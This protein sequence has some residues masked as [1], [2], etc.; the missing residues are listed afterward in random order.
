[1]NGRL[2]HSKRYGRRGTA[3]VEMAIVTPIL[4]LILLGIIEFGYILYARNILINAAHQGARIGIVRDDVDE[5]TIVKKVLETVEE[6]GLKG[7]VQQGDVFPKI[8]V[9][10]P[11]TTITVRIK[12]PYNR[13]AIFGRYMPAD[14]DVGSSCTMFK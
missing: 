7:V 8:V 3:I 13:V 4:L 9:D 11:N 14:F 1:M 10:G 2:G 12:M 5:E 6:T